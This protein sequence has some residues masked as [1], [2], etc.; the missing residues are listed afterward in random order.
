LNRQRWMIALLIVSWTLNVMF[1]VTLY[2]KSQYPKGGYWMSSDPDK[3]PAAPMFLK[4]RWGS[5]LRDH[6]RPFRIEQHDLMKSLM[7][8]FA[9]DSLD[10]EKMVGL[11]DSLAAIKG[12]LQRQFI[13]D[14]I[15]IHPH[16][17]PYERRQV[18]ARAMRHQMKG[19]GRPHRRG[20]HPRPGPP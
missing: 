3:Q 14:M 1:G 20:R 4:K 5:R 11:A 8:T 10:K 16:L 13:V 17:T 2:L 18:F 15:D 12:K 9:E 19:G 7:E 6:V